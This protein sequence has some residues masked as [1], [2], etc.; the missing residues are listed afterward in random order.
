MKEFGSKPVFLDIALLA[1]GINSKTEN[2]EIGKGLNDDSIPLCARVRYA[3]LKSGS[4]SWWIQQ[5][6][7]SANEEQAL[8]VLTS[9]LI[10]GTPRVILILAESISSRLDQLTGA[11]WG[12]LIGRLERSSKNDKFNFDQPLSAVLAKYGTKFWMAFS[13][14]LSGEIAEKIVLSSAQTYRGSDRRILRMCLEHRFL[15][16]FKTPSKWKDVLPTVRAAYKLG[17]IVP[18]GL[19]GRADERSQMPIAIAKLICKGAS[20]Y[21]LSLIEAAQGQLTKF[22]GSKAKAPGAVARNDGWFASA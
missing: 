17:V 3:R 7:D 18:P 14:R 21:P 6:A 10:W 2:G 12:R 11:Q 4:Q 8:L 1:A 16:A 22:V 19:W 15:E 9:L 5:F 13:L 20:D